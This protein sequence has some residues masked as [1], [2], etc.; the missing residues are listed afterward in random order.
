MM[1]RLIQPSKSRPPIPIQ[2]IP[3]QDTAFEFFARPIK[4][5]QQPLPTKYTDAH[6]R[7]LCKNGRFSEAISALDSIA[8]QHGRK[9]NSNTFAR[10]L[11]YCIEYDSIQY[12]RELHARMYLVDGVDPFVETKLVGMYAK[13][14][15][16]A[17]ARKVFDEMSER[18]LFAWSAMIGALS[19]KQRWSEVMDMFGMM[20][21][22][23]TLP[24]DLLLPK[25]LQACGNSGDY[26]MG[27]M[28][29]SLVVR[30]GMS[31]CDLVGNALLSVYVK[32][33]SLSLARKFFE[34]MDG[35]DRVS[36]NTIILGY[37][38]K[39]QHEEAHRLFD[40][41]R[42][43]G[44]EPGLVTWNI[45]IASYSQSG[46]CD[47]AVELMK[48]MKSIGVNPDVFTW[49]SMISGFAKNNRIIQAL[50]LFREILFVGIEPSAVTITS[51][52][53]ACA[54]LKAMENGIELHSL[55]IR[56]GLAD[57]V[58]VGNSLIDMYSKCGDLEAAQQVF[59]AILEKDVYTWN[60]MIGGYCRG[61]YCGKAHDLF[62]KMWDSDVQPSVV[63]WN[64]MISGYI[65]NGDEDQAMDL[66]QQMGK[67]G[68]VKPDTSSW[69]SLISGYLQ[70]GEKNKALGIFRQMQSCG[71][72]PN[73]VTVLTILPACA[74]LL[75]ANKVKE[76]HACVLHG[77]LES[78]I[79]IANSLIDTYAKSGN[80]LYSRA[81]FDSMLS[82]DIISWNALI[83]GYASL[84]SSADALY[85]FDHM[86]RGG[87][88]PNRGTF[89]S[90]IIA[91]SLVKMVDKGK[92]IFSTMAEDCLILPGS[93]H[94]SAMV[95][96]FGRSG[97]LAE[98]IEF[99]EHM[100]TEPDSTV[101]DA[102]LTACR[103]H[104]NIVMSIWAGE[105][106]L[107]LNPRDDIT[108]LLLSQAYSICGRSADFS[109][110]RMSQNRRGGIKKVRGCSL[111]EV[112]NTVYSFVTGDQSVPGLDSIHTW[113]RNIPGNI[114]QPDSHA[115]P[116]IEEEEKEEI[117]GIHSEK[118]ALGFALVS[119]ACTVH[120]IR[121]MK[122]F[123]VCGDCHSTA[124]FVSSSYGCEI[125]V[126]DTRRLHHFK[127]GSCSCG[128][129][130]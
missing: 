41:M 79:P 128:D 98:A 95:D 26:E 83:A 32:C 87:Y 115:I 72:R 36:W 8:Q 3:K 107:E 45:L 18:N 103:A 25:I 19:R 67:G 127:D 118:L 40:M 21:M 76:M 43:E 78:D 89:V 42:E 102:L 116:C 117:C 59:D 129:Y 53:S 57:D 23:G 12:G 75:A 17:D 88:E 27:R 120:P 124:K 126:N 112:R 125:F 24:D 5:T 55:A 114:K 108:R 100:A 60:S 85:A 130:W 68:I 2:I 44:V 47:A 111:I 63:T 93:E 56:M 37:C 73:L 54:S 30:L 65:Q 110:E 6:V 62:S 33:A 14:G 122:N 104:R 7:Y 66:F 22:E 13:C 9:V 119:T 74:N 1:E 39:G 109:K 46:N 77:N 48:K 80:I 20:M 69:N 10:L 70:N 64:A 11:D 90:L 16:L 52:V 28:M 91:Y 99:I 4:A 123:R 113:L 50:D 49:T 81:V 15:S 35:R 38:Q 61:G 121:I 29:H 58:L 97:R 96:L 86:K 34:K 92:Q 94:C 82:K 105:K 106:L 31:F 51:A 71:I 84:G 101:W